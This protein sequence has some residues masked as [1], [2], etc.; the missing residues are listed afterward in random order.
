MGTFNS[1]IVGSRL[2]QERLQG[3]LNESSVLAEVECPGQQLSWK[4][5]AFPSQPTP[6]STQALLLGLLLGTMAVTSQLSVLLAIEL[7]PSLL[8][9]ELC[10]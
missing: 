8:E 6:S 10:R 3:L 1:R 7:W 5:D 4:I 9:G 2:W